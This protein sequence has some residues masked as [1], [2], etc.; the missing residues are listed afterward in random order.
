MSWAE[1]G[2]G[3]RGGGRGGS[4]SSFSGSS[5]ADFPTALDAAAVD[6][7]ALGL[8]LAGGAV[9]PLAFTGKVVVKKIVVVAAAADF[10]RAPT[11]CGFV[12]GSLSFLGG[13]GRGGRSWGREGGGRGGGA[14]L[15][16]LFSF[17]L[18]G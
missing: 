15:S 8:A 9:G 6:A 14:F 13:G 3:G 18:D 10:L 5:I 12:G 17:A 4:S 7:V 16:F 2:R 11:S 1:G